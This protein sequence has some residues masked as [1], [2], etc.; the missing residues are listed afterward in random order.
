MS[1]QIILVTDP[2]DTVQDGKRLLFVNLSPAQ[3]QLVSSCLNNLEEIPTV[4]IYVWN[5]GDD[6]DWLLDKKHKSSFMLFNAGSPNDLV[7]GFMAA[8]HSSYYLGT[9]RMF[10][11]ANVNQILEP[12]QLT[13]VLSD[14]LQ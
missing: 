10:N 3:T 12:Q 7:T 2:D 8:Q 6:V 1:N 4:I 13:D 11:K 14:I 5:D 9:L